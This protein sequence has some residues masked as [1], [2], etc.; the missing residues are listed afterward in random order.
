MSHQRILFQLPEAKYLIV[1]NPSLNSGYCFINGWMT[2]PFNRTSAANVLLR[3][4]SAC[5]T[6]PANII[7]VIAGSAD[8]QHK[9]FNFPFYSP[10]Q[11]SSPLSVTIINTRT[12]NHKFTT[13]TSLTTAYH[14]R[15]TAMTGAY[16]SG[17]ELAE[18]NHSLT[19]N[20]HEAVIT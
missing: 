15:W 7:L 16:A 5:T 19:T 9:P 6:D 18:F 17:D 11:P 13:L 1:R 2:H 12:I 3:A 10:T 20:S 8:S 4:W 14:L